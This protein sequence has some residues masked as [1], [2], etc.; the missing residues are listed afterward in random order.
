MAA[1]PSGKGIW[2]HTAGIPTPE[3]EEEEGSGGGFAA[4][5]SQPCSRSPSTATTGAFLG[6]CETAA[7]KPH[8]LFV[9]GYHG[10][11]QC[12]LNTSSA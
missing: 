2:P 6:F 9:I 7:E 11:S 5:T 4:A 8:C 3:W 1:Q 12:L 10:L